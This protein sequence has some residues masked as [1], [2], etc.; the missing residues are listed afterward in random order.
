MAVGRSRVAEIEPG[1]PRLAKR[2]HALDGKRRALYRHWTRPDCG[3]GSGDGQ[4]R[5]VYD[6]ESYKAGR[7][8][9]G[10]FLS[11]SFGYWTD[12][13]V[14]RLLVGTHDAYLISIDPRTGRPDM[15]FGTDGW[16]DLTTGIRDVQ[17]STNFSA[18]GPLIAGDVAIV[19]SSIADGA[20]NKEAPPGDVKAFDVRTGKLL[21]VFNKRSGAL[22]REIEMDGF[23][24]AAPMTYLHAGKQYLVM[25]V[26]GNEDAAIVAFGLPG[27]RRN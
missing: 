7:P 3:A 27:T 6:P 24:V 4:T 21:Y 19:G 1:P 2:E 16:V 23:A 12:G 10:G 20:R 17:R 9:N 25:A 18:R 15:G 13:T 26:G 14:E 11:R 8:N 5:W 22:V